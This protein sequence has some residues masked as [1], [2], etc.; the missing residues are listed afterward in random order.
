MTA[1]FLLMCSSQRKVEYEI[2]EHFSPE[3][4]KTTIDWFNKGK[5]LYKIHCADCHGIFTGGKENVPNFTDSQI[6]LY[7]IQ[8]LND[9]N[10]HGV[11]KKL[12]T[13]QFN[14][15]ITYL[16]FRKRPAKLVYHQM[17]GDKLSKASISKAP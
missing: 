9:P 8:A 16:R 6:H 12:S 10:N 2:P 7:S 4:R 5:P 1:F 17:E 13:D 15:I 11:M 3:A 14:Y